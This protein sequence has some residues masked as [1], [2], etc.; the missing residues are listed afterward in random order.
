MGILRGSRG[1]LRKRL[2]GPE[3]L[4]ERVVAGCP[5]AQLHL[6]ASTSHT[7]VPK[8]PLFDFL[9]EIGSFATVGQLFNG[10]KLL[11]LPRQVG[12]FAAM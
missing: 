9:Q 10:F 12:S 7:N 2:G 6:A 8:P 11:H 5:L 3:P 4:G 1:H